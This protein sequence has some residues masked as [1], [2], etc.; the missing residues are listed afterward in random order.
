MRMSSKFRNL[1]LRT[2]THSLNA[3]T[4]KVL[5]R[6]I[7]PDYDLHKATG[8]PTS[9]PVPIG[10]GIRQFLFDIEKNRLFPQLIST[11]IDIDQN[12]INGHQVPINDL[13]LL[14]AHIKEEGYK[15]D[16]HLG[17][18]VEDPQV[19]R[20]TNWGIMAP[21]LD[22]N[23][24]FIKLDI[25]GNTALV[26]SESMKSIQTAYNDLA[27]I[28]RNLVEKREGRI[29]NWEG[30]GG[31]AAFFLG[32]NKH[33]SATIAAIEILHEIFLYNHTYT[34]LEDH[35]KLRMAIHSGNITY[36]DD[37][38]KIMDS[39]LLKNLEAMEEKYT[40]PDHIS[41]SPVAYIMITEELSPFFKKNKKTGYATYSLQWEDS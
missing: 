19:R 28:V 24:S 38:S 41:V 13:R 37:L 6:R 36:Q 40:K 8:F 26:R 4:L 9:V 16:G 23:L 25:V 35:L 34:P 3:E 20:S 17:L 33:L 21:G 15:Y 32:G 11:L 12:G 2:L 27:Y 10:D 31:L 30:D 29:W 14:I 5:S 18:F 1:Y 7:F 22:Y 39:E